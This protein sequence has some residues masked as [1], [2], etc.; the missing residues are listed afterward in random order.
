MPAE[1]PRADGSRRPL[2]AD[3]RALAIRGSNHLQEA[4]GGAGLIFAITVVSKALGTAGPV[5]N[6]RR[7]Q[8]LQ[9]LQ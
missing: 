9:S 3:E 1:R 6:C 4:A 7:R 5:M 2:V 8:F